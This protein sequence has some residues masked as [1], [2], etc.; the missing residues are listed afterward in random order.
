MKSPTKDVVVTFSYCLSTSL[1]FYGFGT[2]S[3]FSRGSKIEVPKLRTGAGQPNYM[4]N[5]ILLDMGFHHASLP[6]RSP[7]T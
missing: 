1:N 6:S 4:A 3:Y 7:W 5:I 2:F